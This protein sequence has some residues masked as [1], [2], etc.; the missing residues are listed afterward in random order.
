M[1]N[2]FMAGNPLPHYLG[3]HRSVPY[4]DTLAIAGG[5]NDAIRVDRVYVYSPPP[6][7]SWTL[8]GRTHAPKTWPIA[9]I[10]SKKNFPRCD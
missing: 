9:G 6:V 3:A 1:Q 8:V 10:V 5:R 4:R 2:T 7:D